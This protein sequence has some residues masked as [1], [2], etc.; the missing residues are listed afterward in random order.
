LPGERELAVSSSA[1]GK[2]NKA[3]SGSSKGGNKNQSN[4]ANNNNSNRGNYRCGKCGMPKVNHVCAFVDAVTASASAQVSPMLC[5]HVT[6][7]VTNFLSLSLPPLH[8]NRPPPAASSST[9]SRSSPSRASAF[10]RSLWA[11]ADL[12]LP[13]PLSPRA[14]SRPAPPSLTLFRWPRARAMSLSPARLVPSR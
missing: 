5:V 7:C 12:A 11:N 8:P 6:V 9:R 3:G 13:P 4:A 2:S 14:A 10:S 1:H